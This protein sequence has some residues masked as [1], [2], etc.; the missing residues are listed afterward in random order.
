M[1]TSVRLILLLAMLCAALTAQTHPYS[2]AWAFATAA[3]TGDGQLSATTVAGTG[4][5][6][7]HTMQQISILIQSPGGRIASAAN[8]PGGTTGQATAFLPL[9]TSSGCEDGIFQMTTAGTRETCGV[10]FQTLDLPI[11]TP[12]FNVDPYVYMSEVVFNPISISKQGG[13]STFT[14]TAGKSP[15]CNA[16]NVEIGFNSHSVDAIQYSVNPPP[17]PPPGI[18]HRQT[19]PF[20]VTTAQASWTVTT[21]NNNPNTGN[22]LGTGLI[23]QASCRATTHTLNKYLQVQ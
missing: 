10:T 22:I 21:T 6:D 5:T 9:C 3:E 23:S 14:A 17:P 19:V 13:T 16:S 8:Y 2:N 7:T 20:A 18:G 4:G 15:G 11:Q 12:T 1:R